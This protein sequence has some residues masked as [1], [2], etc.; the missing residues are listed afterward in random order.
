M[1]GTLRQRR[2]V[3]DDL[4]SRYE[5]DR[6]HRWRQHT[7]SWP[8]VASS[9]P[10]RASSSR[11][12]SR[13]SPGAE[14]VY[15]IQSG[16]HEPVKIGLSNRPQRRIGELQTSN[17]DELALRHVIPGGPDVEHR[18]HERFEPALI[19]GEWF[20]REYLPIILSF[21]GGFAGQMVRS[22]DGTGGRADYLEDAGRRTSC[23]DGSPTRSV[24][25]RSEVGAAAA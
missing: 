21:G 18:L 25:R 23:A 20:G 14:F 15:F 2:R 1:D 10:S 5:R 22:Y 8:T 24:Q 4:A 3:R 7:L 12:G 16:D 13:S 9:T 6:A 19:L 11:S 17:L